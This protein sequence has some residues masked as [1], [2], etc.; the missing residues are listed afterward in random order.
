MESGTSSLS[1]LEEIFKL[2]RKY[3]VL[4]MKT[5]GCEFTLAETLPI[6][7]T[8]DIMNAVP[9]EEP[10]EPGLDPA[11]AADLKKLREQ[12]MALRSLFN[13]L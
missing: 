11:K 2:C 5:E 13:D 7:Y 1:E 12:Q 8:R 9:P 6:V 10:I 4:T 3:G